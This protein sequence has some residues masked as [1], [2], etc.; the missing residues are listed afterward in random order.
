M[1]DLPRGIERFRDEIE[2]E[3][4]ASIPPDA[5]ASYLQGM[6]RYH[7]GWSDAELRPTVGPAGKRLRPILCL[8]G[9]EAVG[10]DYRRAL[11]GAAALELIHNFSLVHD[12]I[13]DRSDDRHHRPTVWRL[14]GEAQAIDAGDAILILAELAL[15]RATQ[16][17]VSACC[18]L[19]AVAL[20]NRTCLRLAEGQHLDLGFEGKLDVSSEA[21]FAM[22][23]GKTAALV[24]GSLELGALLGAEDA[25]LARRYGEVGEELG[26]AFQVQ[27]DVL[28]IWGD[29][30]RTGKP[31]AADV[32]QRKMT[33]PV[34]HALATAGAS[35]A[36]ELTGVYAASSSPVRAEQ[37]ARALEI[38]DAA[39]AR[40][41]AVRIAEERY[42][43]A[44][45]GLEALRPEG[46]AA[47]DLLDIA[48][49]LLQRDF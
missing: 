24:S 27:D 32:Y 43:R 28:G 44:L 15:L 33:L 1:A 47:R 26:I 5:P 6:V 30:A 16:R 25:A 14:W 17:G 20:L 18:V 7:L 31:G 11:P 9:A 12:D 19:E 21:Y 10:A 23:S 45:A 38:L 22:I 37:A 3:L 4:R 29:P 39:G 13:M 36:R 2:A 41:H 40:E 42:A 46:S 35:E 48:A 49:F 8:L 34:I